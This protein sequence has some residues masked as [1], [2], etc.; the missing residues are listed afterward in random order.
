MRLEAESRLI[1]EAYPGE[2]AELAAAVTELGGATVLM[3]ALALLY[4]LTRRRE[5]ALVVSYAFAGLSVLLLVKYVL[6]M[7][8]PPAEVHLVPHSDDP[9][10]FPSGHAFSAT[11]VYGGLLVTFDRLRDRVAVVSA[12]ALILVVSLSR[13]VLGYHYLGDVIVGA[14]FGLAFLAT[15]HR[16]VDGRPHRGFAV[17]AVAAVPM[18]LVVGPTGDALLG[19][20]G[21]VGGVLGS[22][23]I[24][25]LPELR[26]RLEGALLAIAGVTV[27]FAIRTF[28]STLWS[29]SPEILSLAS[30]TAANAVL[31]AALLLVPAAVGRIE[32]DVLEIDPLKIRRS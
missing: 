2:Y 19:L 21:S 18:V 29:L 1:R 20:G 7:P 11:L 3:V 30:V 23:R 24:D 27:V 25:S 8:R 31:V 17:A 12:A 9:H 6:A 15:I 16:I 14:V 4:W 26:S 10:G 28:K 32:S 22:L 13:V 5:T